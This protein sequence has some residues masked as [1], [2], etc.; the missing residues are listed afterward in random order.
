MTNTKIV[1]NK[2]T[3]VWIGPK[4]AVANVLEPTLAEL[5]TLTNV[6]EAIK[7]DGFDF[8]FEA[9][10]QD[11]DRALTDAAG[12]ATRGYENFGGGIAFYTPQPSDTSSIY[13]SARNLVSVPHTEL[14]IVTRDGLP[15]STPFAAGQV[16]NTFHVIT[17]ANAHVRGDKNRYYT[18]NMKNKGFAGSNR[19]VPSAA[20]TAIVVT[21]T[22]TVTVG[23][24]A[25]QLK[26]V[27]EGN[28]ITIGAQWITSDETKV[29]VTPH[30]LLVGVAAGTANITATYPGA[31][32]STATAATAS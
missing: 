6:S 29:A 12:A 18:I 4:A 19:I 25:S 28:D 14:V 26:A 5:L 16:V 24:P 11:E 3:A 17:D 15:A 9:S 1:S 2:N 8:A 21:G 20:P 31:L 32:D 10:E 30:G 13:R 27:Y 23:G 7:W 22:A